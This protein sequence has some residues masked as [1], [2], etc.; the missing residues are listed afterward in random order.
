MNISY[1]NGNYKYNMR[2][3]NSFVP[4]LYNGAECPLCPKVRLVTVIITVDKYPLFHYFSTSI[5]RN[6]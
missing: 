5:S 3:L 2:Y 6:V 4:N 1:F